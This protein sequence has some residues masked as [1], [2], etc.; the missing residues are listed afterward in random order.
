MLTRLTNFILQKD[1]HMK[2]INLLFMTVFS[3]IAMYILMYIMV[4]T[5]TNVYSNLNQLYMAGLMTMPM[6]IIELF[7]MREMYIY[8]RLN[9][10]IIA[11]SLA[12]CVV[13]IIFIRNQTA[14]DDKE[15][16]KSMIP[17]H[18]A[19]ILMCKKAPV[20]DPELKKLCQAIISNQQSEIDF[21]KSKLH[22]ITSQ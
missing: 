20:E 11:L 4:D 16:L 18:A 1:E 7:V 10:L 9:T 19:A 14:I 3:F 5:Y 21:M 6:L 12:L 22:Q 15:F 17:H 2:Y 13:F 8:K